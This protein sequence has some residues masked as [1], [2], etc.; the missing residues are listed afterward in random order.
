[1]L[2]SGFQHGEGAVDEHLERQPWLF[3]A[4]RDPDGS[5]VEDDIGALGDVVHQVDVV[6]ISDY[7]LRTWVLHG[8]REVLAS[9]AHQI[10]EHA[11]VA[12]SCFEQ[13]ID[14]GRANGSSSARDQDGRTC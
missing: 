2:G 8:Y 13:V 14:Y 5:L 12:D 9:P 4:L 3:G 7:Q 10:V 6:E 1:M 11:H